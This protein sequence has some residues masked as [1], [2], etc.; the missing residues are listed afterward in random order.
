MNKQS[1]IYF[2]VSVEKELPKQE[3]RYFVEM[4]RQFIPD[5]RDCSQVAFFTSYQEWYLENHHHSRDMYWCAPFKW[6]KPI[7]DVYVFSEDELLDLKKK[8]CGEAWNKGAW[9][10]QE[11]HNAMYNNDPKNDYLNNLTIE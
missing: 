5:N 3:G 1:L 4:N 2:P 7:N 6:L 9:E 8:W 10:E 11:G